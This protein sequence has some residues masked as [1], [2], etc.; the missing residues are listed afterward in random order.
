NDDCLFAEENWELLVTSTHIFARGSKYCYA[1]NRNG[2]FLGQIGNLGQGP[3]EYS[4]LTGFS[5]DEKKQSLY[6]E[7]LHTLL[8]YS[9]DGVFRQSTELP[10]DKHSSS[11]HGISFVRDNLFIGHF[12]NHRGN[13][14]H[15]FVLF[16]QSSKVIKLFDNYVQFTPKRGRAS[17]ENRSMKPLRVGERIYVKELSNDTLFYLNEQNELISR[18]VFDLGQYTSTIEKREY[19]SGNDLLR[20]IY[21]EGIMIPTEGYSPMTGTQ[22]HFFFGFM[23][24]SLSGKYA[25][26]KEMDIPIIA[27][28]GSELISFQALGKRGDWHAVIG[29]YDIANQKT[30]LLDTDPVSRMRGLINDIDGGLSFWPRY[31]TSDNEL[32]DIWRVEDMKEFLTEDY[33]AAHEI[34]DPEAHQKLK[35]LAQKLD[36]EDN[37]VIVIGK[38][39]PELMGEK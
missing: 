33:F 14:L 28:S 36:F 12:D 25:F 8:E 16:D 20:V 2:R 3:G 27:S 11:L 38:L 19:D 1:F 7:T 34:K 6:L 23:A 21:P 18:Y 9:W 31:Y 24:Y 15:N 17:W 4:Y 22:K 5:I 39:K 29:I 13:L 37:P 32:V 10:K 35:E 30:Q 26:P